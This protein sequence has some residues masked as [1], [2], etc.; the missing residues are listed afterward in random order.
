MLRAG[1]E[2]H[3]RMALAKAQLHGEQACVLGVDIDRMKVINDTLGREAGDALIASVGELIKEQVRDSDGVARLGSDEFGILLGNCSTEQSLRVAD[4][5]CQRARQMDFAWQGER[6]DASLSIGIVPLGDGGDG[7]EQIL[8]TLD[9]TCQAAKEQG[10]NQVQVYQHHDA[11]LASRK[12]AMYWVAR[13]QSALREDRFCLH[14]QLIAPME[15]T[16][17]RT[18]YEVLIRLPGDD[19]RMIPPGLFIP[20]AE[21]YG[22]MPAI[23]RWVFKRLLDE[24]GGLWRKTGRLEAVFSINLSGPTLTDSVFLD[25]VVTELGSV[26][27]PLDRLC[28]E[29]TETAAIAKLE[30]AKRF[31]AEVKRMGCSFAL[32]DFGSG[33]SSYA[34]LK[35]LDVDLVKI[36]G[37]FITNILEDPV[38]DVMVQSVIAIA[39]QMG[40]ATVAEFVESS[41]I[42]E[43]LRVLG[44]DYV[45]G[46]IVGK[47]TPLTGILAQLSAAPADTRRTVAS[48]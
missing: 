36:D 40:I 37:S 25:Y 21:R 47:P 48:L 34:Y 22:L 20:P 3:L 15:P 26:S 1:F 28:F 32:D 4:K 2:H 27:F 9:L 45:Q 38:S 30:A 19:G 13:L 33:L 46:Y 12:A 10:L 7:V 11:D 35:N 18:H 44:V 17:H 24:L 43:R 5:L 6:F 23:D 16:T 29:I 8:S 39:R 14:A 31:I 41:A 42:Q